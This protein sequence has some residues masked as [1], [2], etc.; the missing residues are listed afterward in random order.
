[1]SWIWQLASVVL[2]HW[3][4]LHTGSPSP[5]NKQSSDNEL[6]SQRRE[7]E[8]HQILQRLIN[9]Q[10]AREQS[11]DTIY[12]T[13]TTAQFRAGRRNDAD[14]VSTDTDQIETTMTT[15]MQMDMKAE[16][17]VIMTFLRIFSLQWRS[18]G[19]SFPNRFRLK[20]PKIE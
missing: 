20:S 14:E 13:P 10:A 8:R 7:A 18:A 17:K 16:K 15:Q 19:V 1:M 6:G 5:G 3:I 9:S 11:K 12:L 2:T 4:N